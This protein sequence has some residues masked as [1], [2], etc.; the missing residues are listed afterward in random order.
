[1]AS[2]C[3]ALAKGRCCWAQ[4]CLAAMGSSKVGRKDGKVTWMPSFPVQFAGEHMDKPRGCIAHIKPQSGGLCCCSLSNPLSARGEAFSHK[5][6]PPSFP[7]GNSAPHKPY[8]SSML[9]PGCSQSCWWY[10]GWSCPPI[11]PLSAQCH[12]SLIRC[13]YLDL[14]GANTSWFL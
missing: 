7:G 1:M 4:G 5:A 9:E 13:C 14:E 2:P 3:F 12:R 8:T 6:K 11:S 10:G